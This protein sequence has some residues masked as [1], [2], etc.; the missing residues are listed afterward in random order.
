LTNGFKNKIKVIFGRP[1]FVPSDRI[2]IFKR[3]KFLPSTAVEKLPI[4]KNCYIIFNFL[5]SALSGFLLVNYYQETQNWLMFIPFA[6][7]VAFSFT[8]NIALLENKKWADYA[9]VFRLFIFILI[10]IALNKMTFLQ[11]IG[12]TISI[13]A[14]CY[15]LC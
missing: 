2:G 1:D 9:E 13:A 4:L 8:V 6:F 12:I 11:T 7:L 5:L 14:G 15:L 3:T 10:G